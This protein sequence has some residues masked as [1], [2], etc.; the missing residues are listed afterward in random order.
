[1][2]HARSGS[3]CAGYYD[4]DGYLVLLVLGKGGSTDNL[5]TEMFTVGKDTSWTDLGT[6]TK[7]DNFAV[8]I[9]NEVYMHGQGY[10]SIQKWDKATKSWK[11]EKYL[12]YTRFGQVDIGAVV[13]LDTGVTKWCI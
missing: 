10:T 4:T 12:G 8:T 9:N 5:P 11:D 6:I 7:R 2:I 1:M 13:P 3:G